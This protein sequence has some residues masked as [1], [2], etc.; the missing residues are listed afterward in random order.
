MNLSYNSSNLMH[1]LINKRG[2]WFKSLILYI[3]NQAKTHY[4]TYSFKK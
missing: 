3:R 1:F 4:D 2:I